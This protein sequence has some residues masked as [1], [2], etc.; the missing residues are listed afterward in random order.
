MV[1]ELGGRW[2]CVVFRGVV[3]SRWL[4]VVVSGRW[5]CVVVSGGGAVWLWPV[6]EVGDSCEW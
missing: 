5:S 4:W 6:C 3:C 2:S 1:V